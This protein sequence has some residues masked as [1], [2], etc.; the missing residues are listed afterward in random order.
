MFKKT[1]A[2]LIL[3]TLFLS[4]SVT[5]AKISVGVKV[6]DWIEYHIS[7]TG[8]PIPGHDIT[9]ARMEIIDV[10]GTAIKA[11][12]TSLS[13]NGT[14]STITRNFN[15]KEGQ[16]Q[17]WVIIPANLGTGNTFYDS[18][19]GS[20]ITIQGEEQQSLAGATRTITH[21]NTPEKDKQ[22]DKATGVFVTTMDYLQNYTVNAT[23]TATNMWSP[24][25]FGLDQALFFSIIGGIS[26]IMI[27]VAVSTIL[28]TRKKKKALKI[29]QTA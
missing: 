25:I 14:L 20:N 23:A 22:W 8:N 4:T 15:L 21:V 1:I 16:L 5:Q 13:D 29:I 12:V 28:F 11:N 19:T 17:A 10:Q 18:S 2:I 24:Q 6:G 27:T 7:T 26:V 3:L 9:W